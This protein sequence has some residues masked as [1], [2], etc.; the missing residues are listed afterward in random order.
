MKLQYS[1]LQLRI[2]FLYLLGSLIL[3]VIHTCYVN[4][5]LLNQAQLRNFPI[6]KSEPQIKLDKEAPDNK[7]EEEKIEDDPKDKG[8]DPRRKNYCYTTEKKRDLLKKIASEK[9][10]G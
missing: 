3:F 8:E 6:N 9:L 7:V 4:Q 1:L 5:L 10:L 2:L